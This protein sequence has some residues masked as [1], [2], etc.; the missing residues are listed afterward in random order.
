MIGWNLPDIGGAE[1][2]AVIGWIPRQLLVCWG[3]S[4]KRV[5]LSVEGVQVPSPLGTNSRN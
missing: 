4:G 3:G 1:S 5:L 2:A